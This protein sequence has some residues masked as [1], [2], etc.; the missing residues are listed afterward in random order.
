MSKVPEKKDE[1]WN[2][3]GVIFC[4]I[5]LGVGVALIIETSNSFIS[6]LPK[7]G[8]DDGI[9]VVLLPS[10]ILIYE[11]F[12]LIGLFFFLAGLGV[13]EKI[14]GLMPYKSVFP[15]NRLTEFLA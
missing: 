7:Y 3:I 13:A 10:L 2:W 14:L 8:L 4:L 15:E 11:I 9:K 1:G 12:F 6:M 5:A